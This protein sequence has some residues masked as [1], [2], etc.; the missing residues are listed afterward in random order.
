MAYDAAFCMS[1]RSLGIKSCSRMRASQL[2]LAHALG[3]DDL[4][5]QRQVLNRQLAIHVAM[6]PLGLPVYW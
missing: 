4:G 2:H 1:R 3:A 6:N 5:V